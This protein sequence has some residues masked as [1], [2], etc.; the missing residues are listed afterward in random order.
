[1]D[2]AASHGDSGLLQSGKPKPLTYRVEG[3]PAGTTEAALVKKFHTD[4][5]AHIKVRSLVPDVDNYDGTGT[6]TA[7]ILFDA[8]SSRRPRPDESEDLEVDKDFQ[9]LTPLNAVMGEPTAES[10]KSIRY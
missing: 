3:I 6:L 8:S 9:G 4:D 1:M 5:R 7:T 10:V 2:T